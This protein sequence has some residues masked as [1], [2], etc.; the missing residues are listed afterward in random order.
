MKCEQSDLSYQITPFRDPSRQTAPR[1]II[2]TFNTAAFT[3]H[4]L[5]VIAY[6][7]LR[8]ELWDRQGANSASC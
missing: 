6:P 2:R 3:M 7:C 5:P 8:K 1:S 4:D